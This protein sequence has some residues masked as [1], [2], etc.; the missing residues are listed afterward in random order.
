MDHQ[1]IR[2]LFEA[3]Q[4][5]APTVAQAALVAFFFTLA[6]MLWAWRRTAL[7]DDK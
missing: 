7:R 5:A 2:E 1:T 4:R 6:V 3:L